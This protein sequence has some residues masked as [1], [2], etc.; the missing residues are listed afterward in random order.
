MGKHIFV[1]EDNIENILTGIYRAFEYCKCGATLDDVDIIICANGEYETEFFAT[2]EQVITDYDKAVKTMEH[3]NRK[4]GGFIHK[5]VLRALC[6]YDVRRGYVLFRFLQYCFKY[7]YQA[8]D[9]LT[10]EYVVRVMELA[11]KSANE[12]HLFTGI[13]RFNSINHILYATLEPKCNVIPLIIDHFSDRFPGENWIIEDKTRQTFAVHK[14]FSE[15]RLYTGDFADFKNMSDIATYDEYES[16]W[17][18]FFESI[19]IKER[20]NKACQRN[21]LPIWMRT[22]MNE[23]L[24]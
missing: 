3:I 7:G 21:L 20:T 9:N 10:N 13:L 2:Y 18:I 5:E 17:N 4:L 24:S 15:T 8:A 16:L 22:H 19:A 23:F 1:C 12:S 14:A 6:H 11:R